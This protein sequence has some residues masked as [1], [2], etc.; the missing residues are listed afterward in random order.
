MNVHGC[1]CRVGYENGPQVPDPRCP[2]WRRY[3]Q[4]FEGCWRQILLH[5]MSLDKP[6]GAWMTATPEYGPPTYQHVLPFSELKPTA[7]IGEINDSTAQRL[8]GLI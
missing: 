3:T 4:A 5:Q 6:A 8:R 2:A 1:I 7:D